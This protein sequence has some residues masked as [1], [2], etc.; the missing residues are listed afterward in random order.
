M[1]AIR[2]LALALCLGLPS[3]GLAQSGEIFIPG[4]EPAP[5]VQRAPEPRNRLAGCL[6]NPTAASCAGVEIDPN[7]LA[8]E[9]AVPGAAG[10]QFETLVLDL[11]S[12]TVSIAKAPP[13]AP[14]VY[15]AP[16]PVQHGRV[17]YPSVT[18]TIEFDYNSD[19]VRHDQRGKIDQLV[20]A[21]SDP[22]LSGTSYAVIGHTDAAGSEGYNC[23]LSLRRA[24]SVTRMLQTGYVALPLYPVGF[25]EHVLKNAHD[26][27]AAENRRVTFLRLPD[28]PG[29]VLQTAG[30]VCP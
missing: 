25:G 4:A 2:P 20:A 10:V 9:S 21:L 29:A 22:A 6:V 7:G 8:L 15:D 5:E 28:T 23:G 11:D 14:P 17:A 16:E 30:A 13:P 3:A 19:R 1:S 27:G 18:V 12:K 24:A 26:P